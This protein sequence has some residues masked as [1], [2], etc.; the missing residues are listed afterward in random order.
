MFKVN[1]GDLI[2]LIKAADPTIEHI[3]EVE[4][5]EDGIITSKK[6]MSIMKMPGMGGE[7][8]VYPING[9]GM[10]TNSPAIEGGENSLSYIVCANF[11]VYGIVKDNKWI[12]LFKKFTSGFV[13]DP[14]I[15]ETTK[16]AIIGA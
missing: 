14:N 5:F 8:S 10:Q 3:V 9:F 16:S 15:N 7:V 12:D 1:K 2:Y 13:L 4:G 6:M 11:D